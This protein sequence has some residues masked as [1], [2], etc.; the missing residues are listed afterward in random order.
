MYEDFVKFAQDTLKPV[1]K[2]AE[3][4]T[5][6]AVKLMQSQSQSAAQLM[7]NNLDH[8]KALIETKDL[9]VAVEMQTRYVEALN[10]KL[11]NSARENAAVIEA[12]MTES[13][14]I[15]EGSLAEVQ[16]QAMKTVENIEKEISKVSQKAA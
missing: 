12:A 6:V 11:V 7:Q 16:A 2:L 4:N 13:G 1:M 14:K 9:N 5:A 10:D 3:T 15:F 8:V